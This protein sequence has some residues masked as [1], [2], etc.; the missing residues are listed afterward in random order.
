[1]SDLLQ[2]ILDHFPNVTPDRRG[3][4]HVDCPFCGKEAQ[5]GQTHFSFSANG[6]HCFIC[7]ASGG[8]YALAQRLGMDG[9]SPQPRAQH[10]KPEPPKPLVPWRVASKTY[11][12]SILN[13]ARFDLWPRYKPVNRSTI[14]RYSLGYGRLPFCGKDGRWY[15]SKQDWLIVPLFEHGQLVG[16]RGRNL[17]DQ[18]PKWIS[19]TGSAYTLWN[20][21]S[22]QAGDTVWLTEN[23]VDAMWLMQ[24]HPEWKAVAIGGAT[25]WQTE[26][27][28]M[29]AERKP[30]Q[31]IVALDNDLAG[32]ATGSMYKR[33]RSAW[34]A[35]R[36]KAKP[37]EPNG[38]KIANSL[39]A[40]GINSILFKWPADAPAKAGIDWVLSREEKAS[41]Y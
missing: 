7:G 34:I 26:W 1:M 39:L 18:G 19:A 25:T 23:Y 36:P 3:E 6:F 21:D 8:L 24:T 4:H 40:T 27:G 15:E 10:R 17:T 2:V 31:V 30:G 5:R 32:Q 38:P 35:E 29:L 33:L 11:L 12:D 16:L 28:R 9:I 37:P 20:V 14:E 22:V 13:N 41:E